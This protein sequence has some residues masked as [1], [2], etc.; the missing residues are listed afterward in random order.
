MVLSNNDGCIVARS[1]EAK[2]LGIPMGAPL[3]QWADFMKNKEVVVC[4]S[5]FSLYG[6]LSYRVMH[7][8]EL[9]NS[10]VDVYS[11]DEAFL[12]LD[13]I[14]DPL[15]HAC[16]IRKTIL[17]WTGIPISIG[18]APTKTLAKV[19]NEKAKRTSTY[20]GI[21]ELTK[22]ADIEKTLAS[23]PV[24]E[25]WGIGRRMSRSLAKKGIFTAGQ[26]IQQEDTWIKQVFSVVGLRTVWELRGIP[27]FSFQEAPSPKQSIMTS[28]SFGTLIREKSQLEEAIAT[29]A[30]RGSEKL[31]EE[32]R[33]AS[34]LQV[35]IM[36]SPHND[37]L[38][39]YGNQAHF[40]LPEPSNYTPLLI[41]KA[42]EALHTI[43]RPGYAYKK[44]GVLYGGLAS[45]TAFQ[46]DLFASSSPEKEEKRD[47]LMGLI[48][49]ANQRFRYPILQFAAEG[50]EKQ[51]KGKRDQS[52]PRYTTRWDEILT[53]HI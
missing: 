33:K 29:Y 43:F 42:K 1:Q 32:K 10:D 17:Q 11:I 36:T 5:N 24:G 45:E 20:E 12:S 14:R 46:P 40:T 47:Q 23:L 50:I 4:S 16:I 6:D 25:V 51:W 48:D 22:S 39:F 28:R 53:I 37:T 26:L 7:S 31:R 27:C 15:A 3:F 21:C 49:H 30:A 44:A 35:F 34:W 13:G 9:L 19:A 52:S 38:S 2:A 18:I 8:L 41:E